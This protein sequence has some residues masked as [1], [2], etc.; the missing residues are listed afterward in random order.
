MDAQPRASAHQKVDMNPK[1]QSLTPSVCPIGLSPSVCQQTGNNGFGTGGMLWGAANRPSDIAAP[2]KNQQVTS[3][4]SQYSNLDAAIGSLFTMMDAYNTNP[5]PY[6]LFPGGGTRG[7]NSNSFVAGL[8]QAGGFT[9]PNNP[10]GRMPG[11]DHPVPVGRFGVG[12]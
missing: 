8:L 4:P 12:P 2:R 10:G 9:L 6:T 5:V 3:V 1:P 11:W 7:L